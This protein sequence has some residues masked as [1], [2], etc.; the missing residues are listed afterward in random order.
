MKGKEKFPERV[1]NKIEAS[2][3]SDIEFK[4]MVI[5][6][7]QELSEN[8]KELSGNYIIMKRDMETMNKNQERMKNTIYEMRNTLERIKSRFV[9]QRIESAS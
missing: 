1:L 2:N 9:K 8:Y 4:V 5:R 6:M 7:F 3:L